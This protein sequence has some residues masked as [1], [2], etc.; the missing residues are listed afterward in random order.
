LNYTA[1]TLGVREQKM[2]NAIDIEDRHTTNV[3][4]KLNK[5]NAYSQDGPMIFDI[6]LFMPPLVKQKNFNYILTLYFILAEILI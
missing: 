5:K 3:S 1:T 4:R 6:H 2:L